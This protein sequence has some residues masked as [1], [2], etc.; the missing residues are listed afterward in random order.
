MP[1]RLGCSG[2]LLELSPDVGDFQTRVALHPQRPYAL[3]VE[4]R[5]EQRAGAGA[6]EERE[7]LH[8]F[9]EKVIFYFFAIFF[10]TTFSF[11]TE[12]L[13]REI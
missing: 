2:S 6:V 9:D 8:F 5:L 7:L 10:F 12:A 11:T 4:S 13:Q 3:Q 1:P